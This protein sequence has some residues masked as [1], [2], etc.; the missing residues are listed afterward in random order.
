MRVRM[1]FVVLL[2]LCCL[3][4]ALPVIAAFLTV[5]VGQHVH[6]DL[7]PGSYVIQNNVVRPNDPGSGGGGTGVIKK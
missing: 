7:C 2:T 4:I 3:V 1:L 5:N 6:V